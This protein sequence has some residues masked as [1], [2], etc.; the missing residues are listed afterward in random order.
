[1]FLLLKMFHLSSLAFSFTLYSSVD[2]D[3][4]GW[5]RK[6]LDFQINPAN[7]PSSVDVNA[8]IEDALAI[9][10]EV[11]SSNLKVGVGSNTTS[12]TYGDPPT[13]ICSTN[14][15]ADTHA[16]V[17]AVPGAGALS[18]SGGRPVG[19]ILILN[20]QP[21]ANANIANYSA[22]KMK[23][24]LAHEIGH[25]MGLGHSEEPAALMYYDASSKVHL[26]LNQDDIDGITYL[27][28]RS[29]VGGDVPLG[30]GSVAPPPGTIPPTWFLMLP[31]LLCLLL[32]RERVIL[33]LRH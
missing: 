13:V 33:H 15:G 19:G 5:N 26:T 2:P 29:E 7:C 12:T 24:I 17:D 8:L 11:P 21:G 16:D 3:M 28:P 14:F 1:M 31:L 22:V 30:C 10:N 25:V 6:N 4:K 9:W 18:L 32:N 27:Y 23:I 20:A